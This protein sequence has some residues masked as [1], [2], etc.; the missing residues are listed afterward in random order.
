L[1]ALATISRDAGRREQAIGYARK[2]VAISPGD[3]GARRLLAELE[4]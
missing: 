4:R 2:L 3:P 1:Q